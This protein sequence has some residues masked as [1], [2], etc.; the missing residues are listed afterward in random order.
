M[1]ASDSRDHEKRFWT[2]CGAIYTFCRVRFEQVG[3][4][5][6]GTLKLIDEGGPAIRATSLISTSIFDQW[7]KDH[8]DWRVVP[9]AEEGSGEP[10]IEV[11]EVTIA[12]YTV[13]PVWFTRRPDNNFSEHFSNWTDKPV[14][15]AIGGSILKGFR[16]VLD[17]PGAAAWLEKP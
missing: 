5:D 12:A 14:V 15:G 11:P 2:A 8:P 7:K 16:V 13:G 6:G 9:N 4:D 1:E 10:M 3:N 17:Y